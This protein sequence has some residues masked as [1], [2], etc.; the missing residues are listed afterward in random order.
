MSKCEN[1]LNDFV[2]VGTKEFDGV[3]FVMEHSRLACICRKKLSMQSNNIL[4]YNDVINSVRALVVSTEH[5]LILNT[6][7]SSISNLHYTTFTSYYAS[8]K[9]S[10]SKI[11][12]RS[13]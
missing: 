6:F 13:I 7:S 12:P 9:Q 10:L 4:K 2:S 3:L 8:Y 5:T 11:L 1:K